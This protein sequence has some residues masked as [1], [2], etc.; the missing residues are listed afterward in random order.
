MLPVDH[1]PPRRITTALSKRY[2]LDQGEEVNILIPARGRSTF[3]LETKLISK[4]QN[5]TRSLHARL[6]SRV[7]RCRGT[8]M[9]ADGTRKRCCLRRVDD[10]RYSG[11]AVV[12]CLDEEYGPQPHDLVRRLPGSVDSRSIGSGIKNDPA[13]EIRSN[14]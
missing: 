12:H 5:S 9:C 14:R 1:R 11:P 4:W 7:A 6:Q 8:R 13:S 3:R 10:T 2:Q